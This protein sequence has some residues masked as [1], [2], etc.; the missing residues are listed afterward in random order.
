MK[1]GGWL[2]GSLTVEATVV[3]S[4]CFMLTTSAILLGYDIYQESFAYVEDSVDDLNVV[5]IFKIKQGIV[6]AYETYKS[7][8]EKK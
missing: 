8:A 6:N 5:R 7:V 4:I 2:K 1:C 3:V